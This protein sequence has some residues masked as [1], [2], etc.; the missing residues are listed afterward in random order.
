MAELAAPAQM[1]VGQSLRAEPDQDEDVGNGLIPENER[2]WHAVMIPRWSKSG[3][4]VCRPQI[5]GSEMVQ[6]RSGCTVRERLFTLKVL[7]RVS[8][9][10]ET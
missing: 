4:E 5:L 3:G 2:L 9:S 10:G 8:A 6:S 1:V 7:V